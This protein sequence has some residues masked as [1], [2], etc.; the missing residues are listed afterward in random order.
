MTYNFL[1]K[2]ITCN[3]IYTSRRKRHGKKHQGLKPLL[4]QNKIQGI[5][6]IILG[7][8]DLRSI[9]MFQIR[10]NYPWI[11]S[12]YPYRTNRPE[13]VYPL[14]IWELKSIDPCPMY[15]IPRMWDTAD[16]AQACRWLMC[17]VGRQLLLY[18]PFD[19]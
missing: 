16:L 15:H 13:D 4:Q 12:R 1:K 14:M 2:F 6:Q 18:V 5:V 11:I 8:H 7:S 3:F 10:P 17:L 19:M 9:V